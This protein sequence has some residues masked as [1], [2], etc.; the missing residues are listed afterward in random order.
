MKTKPIAPKGVF[1]SGVYYERENTYKGCYIR[2]ERSQQG[3][4]RTST[5]IFTDG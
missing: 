3:V 1:C 2:Q 5:D 4:F